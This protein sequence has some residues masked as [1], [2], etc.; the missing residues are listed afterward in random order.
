LNVFNPKP[1]VLTLVLSNPPDR[2]TYGD[3]CV[4]RS[5]FEELVQLSIEAGTINR[6]IPYEKYVDES[7]IQNV[8]L[9][10]T[11]LEKKEHSFVRFGYDAAH[12]PMHGLDVVGRKFARVRRRTASRLS[13]HCQPV[14]S[15]GDRLHT[16]RSY[17]QAHPFE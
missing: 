16:H 10:Q 8:Q 13:W 6:P 1:E 15:T 3:L 14:T 7:F 4:I 5:D 11:T 9:V 12:L 17:R 2:V